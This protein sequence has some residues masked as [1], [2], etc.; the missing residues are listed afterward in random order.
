MSEPAQRDE[1]Y[2]SVV[3][4]AYNEA[5]NV[6]PLVAEVAETL[7]DLGRP[8]EMV[9]TND[10]SQDETP[11]ILRQLMHECGR[12][13]VLSMRRRSGQTAAVDAALRAARGQFVA[14]LDADRQNDPHDIPRLLK[15]LEAGE[16]DMVNGW[17]KDRNDPWLR[18]VS[19]KIANGVRNWLTH[20]TIH[21]SACG[22]KVFRRECLARLKLYNG[23]HRFM[24]TLMRMEGYRVLEVPVNH[25]PRTAGTAKYGVW[26]RVFKALRDAFAIRWMQSR[27]V[28]YEADEWERQD[29]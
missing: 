1:I 4:P 28:L 5:E 29:G 2:L 9:I 27:T 11:E 18:L 3:A 19:T 12:L 6:G 15:H 23:M 16:C 7:A 14:T 13:R 17:R 22:L 26:N 8:W 20:E 10:G 24:P 25:R 21:D